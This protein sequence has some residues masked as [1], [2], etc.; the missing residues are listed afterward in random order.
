M[1]YLAPF[2]YFQAVAKAGSVRKAAEDLAITSSALNRRIQD[3]ELELGVPLFERHAGGLRLNAAGELTLSFVQTQKLEVA[4]LRSQ[5]ADVQGLRRGH[6]AL[7]ASQALTARELPLAIHDFAEQ[8]PGVTFDVK[9]LRGKD[10]EAWLSD[11]LIEVAFCIGRVR[12]PEFETFLS[13]PKRI[14]AAVA[15]SH[16]LADARELRLSQLADFNL[17]LPHA[18]FRMREVLANGFKKQGVPYSPRLQTD[19]FAMGQLLSRSGDFISFRLIGQDED[20]LE[21]EGFRLIPLSVRDLPPVEIQALKLRNA[22]L[23]PLAQLFVQ[24]MAK[25]L[26][27][28]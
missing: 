23:T 27:E 25:Q 14:A 17:V 28:G 26:G 5:I 7:A 11:H 24:S 9:T 10:E 18:D 21:G 2:D 3:L 19:D 4:K 15:N 1:R 20:V 13:V 12:G 6:I 8:H 16:P 22:R